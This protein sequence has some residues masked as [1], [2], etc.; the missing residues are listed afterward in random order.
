[1]VGLAARLYSHAR[2][3]AERQ[4]A[5]GAEQRYRASADWGQRAGRVALATH[6]LS[7]LGYFLTVWGRDE[8]AK[9]VLLETVQ[10]GEK[11]PQS[12]AAHTAS[13]LLGALQRRDAIFAG[14]A[15]ALSAADVRIL[16]VE[17]LPSKDME[18]ERCRLT[19]KINYWHAAEASPK[20]C[21]DTNEAA[22]IAICLC[23]H[24]FRA[25]H[26]ALV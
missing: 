7:R 18:A 17:K 11:V 5:K 15:D 9:H 3:L 8:E 21:F 13:Y 19:G 10:L 4:Q 22:H 24:L 14:D 1:M 26:Q 20:K 12:Q 6:S 25:A 2:W 16:A 23:S